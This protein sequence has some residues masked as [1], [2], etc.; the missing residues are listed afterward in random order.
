MRQNKRELIQAV[1]HNEK[2]DR[3]PVGFWHHFCRTRWEQMLSH[4]RN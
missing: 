2:A 3:I 1:F 4:I